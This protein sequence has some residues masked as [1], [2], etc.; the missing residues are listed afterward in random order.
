LPEGD[1]LRI[2]GESCR[3]KLASSQAIAPPPATGHGTPSTP[4]PSATPQSAGNV[5]VIDD[6]EAIA[7]YFRIILSAERYA[8]C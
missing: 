5:L 3:A 4:A 2:P 1:F 7:E 6:E 8:T